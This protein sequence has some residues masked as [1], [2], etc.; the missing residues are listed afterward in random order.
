VDQLQVS[1]RFICIQPETQNSFVLLAQNI[2]SV[3]GPVVIELHCFI[4]QLIF[5]TTVT[6]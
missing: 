2:W 1:L 3:P 5:T 4:N 6:E